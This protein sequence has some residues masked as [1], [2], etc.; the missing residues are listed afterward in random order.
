M[1]SELALRVDSLPRAP[2]LAEGVALGPE[3]G[4]KVFRASMILDL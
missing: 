1:Q 2:G 4:K 3:G